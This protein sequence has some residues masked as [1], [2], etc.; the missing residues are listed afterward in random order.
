MKQ[1]GKILEYDPK[2]LAQTICSSIFGFV[3]LQVSFGNMLSLPKQEKY[4]KESI[5]IFVNGI[6]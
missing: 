6:E 3:F 5:K 4:V 1:K 2:E